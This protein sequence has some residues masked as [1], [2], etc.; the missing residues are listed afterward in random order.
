MNVTS[1]GKSLIGGN[2]VYEGLVEPQL[3]VIVSAIYYQ[4]LLR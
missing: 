3:L 4:I 1:G 2:P